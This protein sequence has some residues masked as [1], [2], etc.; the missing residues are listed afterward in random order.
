MSSVAVLD[1]KDGGEERR[2]TLADVEDADVQLLPVAGD[3]ERMV[4]KILQR[5]SVGRG[6][7]SGEIELDARGGFWIRWVARRHRQ[8]SPHRFR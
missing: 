5:G 3:A 7:L 4:E 1:V 6:G 8:P 2:C